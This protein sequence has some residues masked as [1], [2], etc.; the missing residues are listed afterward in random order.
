MNYQKNYCD[1]I[2]RVIEIQK[3]VAPEM[4]ET[5]IRRYHILSLVYYNQPI[6]RRNLANLMGIG[7]RIIRGETN[8]LREQGMIFV[9]AEG[10]NTTEVGE[11][12]LDVLK[13]FIH[14]LMG[15]RKIE[16]QVAQKLK[17]KK[18]FVI[19]SIVHEEGVILREIGKSASQYVKSLLKDNTVIGITGG[20]TMRMVAEEMPDESGKNHNITV[21]PARGG[22]GREVE[23][24]A[25]T[26][27]ATLA[28][29]LGG[30]Y[31]LL[32][33]PDNISKEILM[34]LTQE[35]SIKDVIEHI[36][37]IEIFI[38]GIG[39]ADMMTKRREL[40]KE[41]TD[42]LLQQGAVAE[43]F[44]YYFNKSGN[45]IEEVNSVG[46]SL[47]KYKKLKHI[48]AAAAGADKAEALM[49]VSRLNS[50]LVAVIDEELAK[51]ILK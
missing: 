20:E 13:E 8:I 48:I 24:Q 23:K 51:E 6:G 47:E 45:V 32:H 4:M 10:M 14:R 9:R 30:T 18:V 21:I 36:N 38:F 44:G 33:M 34:S 12:T 41:K 40:S 43:A 5:L 7:E 19:P 46:V 25:N 27:A 37:E 42:Y 49:A 15:L 22:F 3:K 50:D 11:N 31:K 1:D 39:R 26:I 35:P 2:D 29:K 16:D 17:I 28:N